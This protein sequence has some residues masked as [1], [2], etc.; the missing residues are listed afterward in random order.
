[1]RIITH[2]CDSCGTVLAGNV[3][4]RHRVMKCVGL[5]CDAVLRFKDLPEDEREHVHSNRE[6]Y[7]IE[8]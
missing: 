5:D 8:D 2:T 6:A 7:T 1:M 3:L 4:E